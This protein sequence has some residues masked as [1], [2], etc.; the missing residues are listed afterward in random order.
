MRVLDTTSFSKCGTLVACHQIGGKKGKQMNE[1]MPFDVPDSHEQWLEWELE[2][3]KHLLLE[4]YRK[5]YNKHLQTW[6]VQRHV[7]RDPEFAQE[8]QAE[9]DGLATLI[10]YWAD[11]SY[12]S[13]PPQTTEEQRRLMRIGA[14]SI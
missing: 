4:H 10:T 9:R 3:A 13:T 8:L 11:A 14:E 2:H 7:D 5:A 6:E 12:K 1:S